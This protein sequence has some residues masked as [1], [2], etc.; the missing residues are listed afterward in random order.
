MTYLGPGTKKT[1][2]RN[3]RARTRSDC[4][5]HTQQLA[6][7]GWARASPAW[8]RCAIPPSH[9]LPAGA[10]SRHCPLLRRGKAHIACNEAGHQQEHA[11]CDEAR[12]ARAFG[13]A[14]TSE[15]RP[16]CPLRV[17]SRHSTTTWS[18][19]MEIILRRSS[20]YADGE[21]GDRA[22][23]CTR[24]AGFVATNKWE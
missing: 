23:C 14:L 12:A 21:P 16:E 7:P 17:G 15:P 24:E 10:C 19:Q 1:S 5:R 9:T 20:V 18:A 2:A 22:K 6:H 13:G 3:V 8:Q 4:V 11:A